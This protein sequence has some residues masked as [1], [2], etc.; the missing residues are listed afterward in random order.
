VDYLDRYLLV[1][2]GIVVRLERYKRYGVSWKVSH[3]C[4]VMLESG[5]DRF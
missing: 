4:K 5:K 1:W 3:L 2:S